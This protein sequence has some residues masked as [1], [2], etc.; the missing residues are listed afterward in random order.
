ML[1]L[2]V[3]HR[4]AVAPRAL[5]VGI[6]VA[7][8]IVSAALVACDVLKAEVREAARSSVES[9]ISGAAVLPIDSV[10]K[11]TT[12]KDTRKRD[13]EGRVSG[14]LEVE[15]CEF[16]YASIGGGSRDLQTS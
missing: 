6:L 15:T 12:S 16:V 4:G 10:L 8:L 7:A 1:S 14:T 3:K 5:L 11:I 13:S 2:S 9:S